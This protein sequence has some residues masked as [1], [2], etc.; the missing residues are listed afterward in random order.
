[1]VFGF[2]LPIRW[3]NMYKGT[4]LKASKC[5]VQLSHCGGIGDALSMVFGH[6][7]RPLHGVAVGVSLHL[8]GLSGGGLLSELS[9]VVV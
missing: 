2:L 4:I 1:M 8:H 3:A 5:I 9:G 7:S 6:D